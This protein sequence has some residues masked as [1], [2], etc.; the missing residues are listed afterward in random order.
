MRAPVRITLRGH[1]RHGDHFM[2]LFAV[3]EGRGEMTASVLVSSG[4]C[5]GSV[6][7]PHGLCEDGQSFGPVTDAALVERATQTVA[8]LEAGD[9]WRAVRRRR[10]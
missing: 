6:S 2:L 5:G 9:A 4:S 1:K 7:F 3:D 8:L 10:R